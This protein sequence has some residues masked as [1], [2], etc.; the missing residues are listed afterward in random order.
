MSESSLSLTLAEVTEVT[1]AIDQLRKIDK[2]Q[3]LNCLL[4][5][6]N[7]VERAIY[8]SKDFDEGEVPLDRNRVHLLGLGG[9]AIAGELILDM[10]YP[11]RAIS[12]HRGTQMPHDKCG[13]VVSSY[14]GN[15]TEVLELSNHLH[16]GLRPVVYLTSGGLLE[17]TGHD[18]SIPTW[19]MPTGYQPRAAVGWSIGLVASLLDRWRVVHGIKEKL[20]A[21]AKGFRKIFD[22]ANDDWIEH[23]LIR[24]G[25]PIANALKEKHGIIFHSLSCTGAARRF[26]AQITENSKQAAFVLVMPEAMHNAV[27]GIGGSDPDKWTL[28]FMS[29]PEDPTSLRDGIDR[30]SDYFQNSGFTCLKFPA[31]G[32][33]RFELTL[34]RLILADMASLF[35]AGNLNVDPT[36]LTIIP[37]LKPVQAMPV[38]SGE[39]TSN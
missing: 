14:S 38:D 29:D 2:S 25:L 11:Q 7:Q 32:T 26:A 28:I 15:T 13:V 6:P 22:T 17:K 5:L 10:L 18:N 36:P 31:A 1:S 8:D 30:T 4:E 33:N 24:A 3:M 12:V 23:P 21:T 34:S 27:E 39:E 16:G 35:L 37:K 9:S 20:L 19:K